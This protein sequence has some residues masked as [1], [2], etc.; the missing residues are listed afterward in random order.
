MA[1]LPPAAG[2]A[3]PP[4]QELP[5]VPDD[6]RDPNNNTNADT[7]VNNNPT[8]NLATTNNNK[9]RARS[10]ED[11]GRPIKKRASRACVACRARKVRCDVAPRTLKAM[12]EGT[13]SARVGVTCNNCDIDG[14]PCLLDESRRRKS[15]DIAVGVPPWVNPLQL[16]GHG[17]TS[18]YTSMD[19]TG[20]PTG[21]QENTA[22]DAHRP[23]G[24]YQNG[25][26]QIEQ[27]DDLQS[28]GYAPDRYTADPTRGLMTSAS[29][30]GDLERTKLATPP[31]QIP[32]LLK[33]QL[34]GFLKPL[35]VRMASVDI[36]HLYAKGALSVPAA[37]VRNALLQ[38]YC[39]WVH[40]YMPTLEL[41]RVLSVINDETGRS[42]Q[43]SLLLFQAMM[44]AG[45]GFVD[46]N[47]LAVAGYPNRKAARKAY[48][49]KARA[50]YDLDYE[51][52][53]IALI[54]SLLL[55]TYWY[56][57]PE[58]PKDTWHW[59]GVA[60][61]LAHT[62]GLHRDSRGSAL[63][64]AKQKLWKRIWFSCFMRDRLIA[65][66]M[67]R[68]TRI[69]EA[70][71]NVP[72]VEESDFEIAA[73]PDHITIIGPECTLLRDVAAQRQLARMC[74]AKIQLC[75]CIAD[76]LQA[77]YSVQFSI[78]RQGVTADEN[79]QSNVTLAPRRLE[80]L[81]EVEA[82]D[83]KLRAWFAGLDATCEYPGTLPAGGSGPSILVQCSLLHMVYYTTVSALHRPQI[84]PSTIPGPSLDPAHRV[85]AAA[86]RKVFEASEKITLISRN[87]SR[88]Q[89]VRFLP[90]AGVTVLLPALIMHLFDIK[91]PNELARRRALC[92]F[93]QCMDVLEQ[94]REAYA[95]A[96]LAVH[97]MEAAVRLAQIG[98]SVKPQAAA[99]AEAGAGAQVPVPP[100]HPHG[101]NQQCDPTELTPPASAS[102]ASL[103]G[104]SPLLSQG[105]GVG[106]GMYNGMYPGM[107]SGMHGG[108][109][110]GMD[111][112]M[113]NGMDDCMSNGID[114]AMDGGMGEGMGNNIR[115]GLG[116]GIDNSMDTDMDTGMDDGTNMGKDTGMGFGMG[117]G[118]GMG[119]GMNNDVNLGE[120]V[121]LDNSLFA[122][123]M[124][125][126]EG[127]HCESSLFP[128]DFGDFGFGSRERGDGVYRGQ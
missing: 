93:H 59:M 70:D 112:R 104:P 9:K 5:N 98:E 102:T 53:R 28:L 85:Q 32:P 127:S 88:W 77:Q 1:D 117:M 78:R 62:V 82:C 51:N 26:R 21:W 83:A 45:A 13:F 19:Q 56:E 69:Q 30:G 109:H 4:N 72:M 118:A 47:V 111:E 97:F 92:G 87:L 75:T 103:Q 91:S 113:Q 64:P 12:A 54:Q 3:G 121:H 57:S 49:Q 95:S 36:E 31:A 48:F 119:T 94:L 39:E 27:R 71:Y 58:D 123:G 55:M 108:V 43:L 2:P 29:I 66:G 84:M 52:D 122:E 107:Y 110:N 61:S 24:L 20:S 126:D 6:E 8:T 63:A 73:L 89:L 105:V 18:P 100:S 106:T 76:V 120:F 42:G 86:R 128:E 68:P 50:L 37:M 101:G 15:R 116:H 34:P 96:D 114:E 65:L 90:T 40:P 10:S 38:A 81:D 7:N 17:N 46:K 41:H 25:D 79:T 67:R 80:R 60:I 124:W 23:H 14:I 99:E 22:S 16:S 115:H 33:H 74:M 125:S 11:G 44:F 35:P